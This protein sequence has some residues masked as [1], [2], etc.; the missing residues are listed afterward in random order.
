MM[1][2]IIIFGAKHRGN[3]RVLLIVPGPD[4][5]LCQVSVSADT[6]LLLPEE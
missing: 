3:A 1:S 6:E 5:K 2:L 4:E